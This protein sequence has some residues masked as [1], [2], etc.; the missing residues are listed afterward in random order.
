MSHDGCHAPPFRNLVC[1]SLYATTERTSLPT[2]RLPRQK[3]GH[4]LRKSP[5][6]SDSLSLL[7][8]VRRATT[9]VALPHSRHGILRSRYPTCNNKHPHGGQRLQGEHQEQPQTIKSAGRTGLSIVFFSYLFLFCFNYLI[10]KVHISRD[11]CGGNSLCVI[12]KSL[13]FCFPL[14]IVGKEKQK[15][16]LRQ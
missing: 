10:A 14:A 13:C 8:H 6:Q 3:S 15:Q 16:S 5:Y 12:G 9:L 7:W 1:E 2:A 11:I 4:G